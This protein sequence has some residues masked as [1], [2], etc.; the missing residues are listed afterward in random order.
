MAT[1]NVTA[2]RPH[3]ESPDTW[4]V[5][6]RVVAPGA[7]SYDHDTVFT[8]TH[9]EEDARHT[10]RSLCRSGYPVRLERVQC[11]PLPAASETSLA[12]MRAHNPQ[13]PG[14][15]LRRVPGH[16]EVRS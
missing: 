13:N 12:E 1:P 16:W 5:I 9:R 7:G 15:Q 11:G 2:I 10:H 6:W 14:T 3:P 8:E 4:P